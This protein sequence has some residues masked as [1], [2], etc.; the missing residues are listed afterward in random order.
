[1]GIL[2]EIGG[3]LGGSSLVGDLDVTQHSFLNKE[4]LALLRERMAGLRDGTGGAQIN[5][6][7]LSI[8]GLN[9]F[10]QGALATRTRGSADALNAAIRGLT[11]IAGR[12]REDL[13]K[14]IDDMEKGIIE[15]GGKKLSALA[16]RFSGKGGR[17]SSDFQRTRGGALED[18]GDEL[19]RTRFDMEERFGNQQLQ[20]FQQLQ[21]AGTALSQQEQVQLNAQ[22]T[23]MG[24]SDAE[25]NRILSARISDQNAQ[26]GNKQLQLQEL[27][28]LLG[29]DS[30]ENI[31][32]P[33]GEN[34]ILA[35][36]ISAGGS[37]GGGFLA[38]RKPP[39]VGKTT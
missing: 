24:F 8:D 35:A 5:T 19:A 36:L 18:I 7:D 10:T 4:Q 37:V 16:G 15:Q 30:F 38:G 11:D 1:M 21:S 34:P 23:A 29:Q 33:E 39:A 28:G 3:M 25:K 22:L 20:A 17:G 9:N 2:D 12:G 13:N 6:D 32:T 27:L 26:Q 31:I 14:R